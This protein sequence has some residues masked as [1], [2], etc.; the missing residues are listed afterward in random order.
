MGQI[1]IGLILI[2]LFVVVEVKFTHYK[3]NLLKLYLPFRISLAIQREK[4]MAT[5]SSTLA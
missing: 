4:T 2:I 5:H 1:L 3:T